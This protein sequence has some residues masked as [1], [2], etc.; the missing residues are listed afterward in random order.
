MTDDSTLQDER[1][2]RRGQDAEFFDRQF[3]ERAERLGIT[4]AIDAAQKRAGASPVT[5]REHLTKSREIWEST[6]HERFLDRLDKAG[7]Q[8]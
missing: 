1:K 3:K 8:R 7:L 5:L 4:R 6:S 2:A